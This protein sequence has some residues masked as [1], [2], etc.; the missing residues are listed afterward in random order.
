MR[1]Y[2]KFYD[3]STYIVT[4]PCSYYNARYLA[5]EI[6]K[7]PVIIYNQPK[8]IKPFY[9]RVNDDGKTVAAFD[10]VVPKVRGEKI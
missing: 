6:Y 9:V 8:K 5:G 1:E 7:R 10:V 3:I 2:G 4:N